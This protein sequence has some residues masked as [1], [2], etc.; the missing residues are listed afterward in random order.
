MFFKN[1]SDQSLVV[2]SYILTWISDK[3]YNT[4]KKKVFGTCLQITFDNFERYVKPLFPNEDYNNY[5]HITIIYGGD[6]LPR[7][8]DGSNIDEYKLTTGLPLTIMPVFEASILN[9]ENLDEILKNISKALERS[10]LFS[11]LHLSSHLFSLHKP[12]RWFYRIFNCIAG[13]QK[14]KVTFGNLTDIQSRTEGFHKACQTVKY[15][16]FHSL[17]SSDTIEINCADGHR[18]YVQLKR[19]P[20][21][22]NH[23]HNKTF[24]TLPGCENDIEYKEFNVVDTALI[25][26][27]DKRTYNKHYLGLFQTCMFGFNDQYFGDILLLSNYIT[28]VKMFNNNNTTCY[29]LHPKGVAIMLKTLLKINKFPKNIEDDINV[30]IEKCTPAADIEEKQIANKWFTNAKLQADEFLANMFPDNET[31]SN[32][33]DKKQRL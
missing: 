20:C 15:K 29:K 22:S 30:K 24:A 8:K 21:V 3:A 9:H 25:Y 23:F 13:L 14:Y 4:W 5:V 31:E 26:E 18:K 11:S 33:N 12:D 2:T 16:P 28:P 6:L 17:P 27:E 7:A 19:S 32:I 10:A 1:L